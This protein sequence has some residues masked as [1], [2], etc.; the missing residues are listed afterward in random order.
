M[1][2][3]EER[4]VEAT[5]RRSVA[6]A[7]AV[8]EPARRAHRAARARAA[9]AREDGPRVVLLETIPGVGDLLG[10]TIASEIGDVS[11]FPTPRKL[12]GYAGLA[13]R[14]HQSGERSHTGALSKAGS[15][16]LRWAA[17]EAAHARLAPSEPLAPALHDDRQAR[18][19]EP[20]QVRRRAQDPDRLLA[21]PQPPA[22]LQAG[23]LPASGPRSRQ[24][25]AAFWPPDGP[26]WN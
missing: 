24:A 26:A 22:T 16:T 9:P 17:V 8:I 4:G 1:A 14:V 11:R 25:P 19:Q 21:H 6:E 5:W 15:R 12:I 20:R 2:L 3:L 10:L 23:P 18:R 7:L 13:P